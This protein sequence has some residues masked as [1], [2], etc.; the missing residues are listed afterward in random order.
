MNF[1]LLSVVLVLPHVNFAFLSSKLVENGAIRNRVCHWAS[2]DVDPSI[3]RSSLSSITTQRETGA[4][5][6]ADFPILDQDAYEGKPLVYLDSAASSQKPTV[7]ID[8]MNEY[9]RTT[10]SNVH[11][12]AHALASRAT[13][14]YEWAREQLQSFINA[15][16]R[17]EVIFV[18]GATEAINLVALSWGQ[19][20]IK[21]GDEIILSVMEH[22]SNLVPWQMLAQQKGAVLK[23]VELGRCF[24]VFIV[25]VAL[26][27]LPWS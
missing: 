10:H 19:A 15:K 17:E 7:V 8:K 18:R 4:I 24:Y 3:S 26:P 5:N 2:T 6:R 14:Q 23:F 12:G 21:Q 22:H 1:L 9:Y 16:H 27:L 25:T 11:R 13:T 20:N